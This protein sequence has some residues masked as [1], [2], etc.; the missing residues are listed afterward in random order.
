MTSPRQ[1]E[2]DTNPGLDEAGRTL[3]LI[4]TLP[5][6]HGL[7]KRVKATLES[8]PS[9]GVVVAWPF[10][11]IYGRGYMRAAAAAAIVLVVA[12]GGWGVYSHIQVATTPSAVVL[13]Q[14]PA[15]AGGFSAAGAARKPQT[16]E[17]PVVST[18]VTT[19]HE[20]DAVSAG[21]ETKAEPVTVRKAIVPGKRTHASATT[22]HTPVPAV[23]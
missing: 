3:R 11:S 20:S 15:G 14:M 5:A 17:G 6:P 13:P 16:L 4:A 7:E 2:F 9:R 22:K 10:A 18:P 8:A 1:N 23:R 19:K 12:G 21:P